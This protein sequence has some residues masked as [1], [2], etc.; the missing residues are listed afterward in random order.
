MDISGITLFDTNLSEW[1]NVSTKL[2]RGSDAPQVA[3][4][5]ASAE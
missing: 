5:Q 2:N 3:A 4:P 1:H